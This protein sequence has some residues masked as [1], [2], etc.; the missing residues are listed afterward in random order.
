MFLREIELVCRFGREKRSGSVAWPRRGCS[1]ETRTLRYYIR[2]TTL[3]FNQPTP[4]SGF[5]TAST[6]AH[7][8]HER[9]RPSQNRRSHR[10]CLGVLA[11]EG[12]PRYRRAT[13]SSPNT[14]RHRKKAPNQERKG[15]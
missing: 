11:L 2:A 13:G 1:G 5:T 9:P 8:D 4:L 15:S 14:F 10:I 6:L 7:L 3:A 12:P